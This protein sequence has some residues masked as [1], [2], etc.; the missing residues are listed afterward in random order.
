MSTL[1]YGVA[2][3]AKAKGAAETGPGQGPGQGLAGIT[4]LQAAVAGLEQERRELKQAMAV[5]G[6]QVGG[7]KGTGVGVRCPGCRWV[8][9][10]GGSRV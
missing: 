7:G 1:T 9:G 3:L 10:V 4:G 8:Q 5:G 6:Q 2:R